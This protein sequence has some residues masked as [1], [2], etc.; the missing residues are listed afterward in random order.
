MCGVGVS[1]F[2]VR[3]LGDFL[4][5]ALL[6]LGWVYVCLCCLTRLCGMST[7]LVT[8]WCLFAVFRGGFLHDAVLRVVVF[9][10][11]S[12]L[13]DFSVFRFGCGLSLLV[14]FG[15]FSAVLFWFAWV[16]AL[17][18]LVIGRGS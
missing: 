2:E 4:V 17:G 12:C 7:L 16:V 15:D 5:V 10:W 9:V 1:W 3:W 8:V 13:F 11:G 6:D 14:V 18:C